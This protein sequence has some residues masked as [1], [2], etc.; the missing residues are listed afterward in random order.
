MLR[1]FRSPEKEA[2]AL[3]GNAEKQAQRF[4]QAAS[5]VQGQIQKEE[6]SITTFLV[7]CHRVHNLMLTLASRFCQWS[8][9]KRYAR[10]LHVRKLEE[11]RDKTIRTG[12][13]Y[14]SLLNGL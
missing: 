6:S 3:I 14:Q 13:A 11:L 10:T 8:V 9:R 2:L 1:V 12:K 4:F 5:R 7:H